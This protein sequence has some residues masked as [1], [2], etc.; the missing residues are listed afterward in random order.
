[1][2]AP[3]LPG[4]WEADAMVEGRCR[5]TILY[6]NITGS[7]A[8]V[9]IKVACEGLQLSMAPDAV[10][11]PARALMPTLSPCPICSPGPTPPHPTL[12]RCRH[13]RYTNPL[14]R[15]RIHPLSARLPLA[16]Q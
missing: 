12:L 2:T 15:Y 13:T 7:S 6:L 11:S 4:L 9:A 14:P 1:M 8:T 10:P 3:Q 5:Y 16:R